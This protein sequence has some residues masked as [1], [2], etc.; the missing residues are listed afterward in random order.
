MS[1]VKEE[2]VA[3]ISKLPKENSFNHQSYCSI[4]GITIR[5]EAE[6]GTRKKNTILCQCFDN[7]AAFSDDI[8]Q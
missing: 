1:T 6:W 8:F 2:A 7:I 4:N 3:A 5:P